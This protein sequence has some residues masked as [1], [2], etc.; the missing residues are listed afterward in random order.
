[1]KK[2]FDQVEFIKEV[3]NDS[4][5]NRKDPFVQGMYVGQ[6]QTVEHFALNDIKSKEDRREFRKLCDLISEFSHD[7]IHY[8]EED[9]ESKSI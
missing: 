6:L 2:Y 9:D 5:C 4:S 7:I 3:W 1:M 8:E